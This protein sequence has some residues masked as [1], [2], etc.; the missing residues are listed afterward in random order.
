MFIERKFWTYLESFIYKSVGENI[1]NA[2]PAIPLGGI[3]VMND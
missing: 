3:N 1:D 2:Q